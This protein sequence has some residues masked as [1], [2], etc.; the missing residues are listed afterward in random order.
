MNLGVFLVKIVKAHLFKAHRHFFIWK[1]LFY[2]PKRA[3]S[4]KPARA[5]LQEIV[6]WK[7]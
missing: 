2:V 7:L 4:G 3:R 1:I 5:T 6:K